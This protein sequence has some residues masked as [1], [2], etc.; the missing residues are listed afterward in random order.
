MATWLASDALD[1]HGALTVANGWLQLARR[2]LEPLATSPD[3]GWLAFHEGFVAR[4]HDDASH[5]LELARHAAEC[6]RRFGVVDL[7][8]L[9]LALEG[10]TL[11]DCGEVVEG[12][13]TLD[14]AAATALAGEADIP[15]SRAWTCC[16]LVTACA[17]VRDY[18]RAS[19]WCDRIAE[20]AERYGSRYMLAFCRAEYGAIDVW[21]GRWS[22][23]EELLSAAL[24]DFSS[25]RPGWAGPARIELA[26]LKRRQGRHEEAVALLERSDA[27]AALLVRA[28]LELDR[29]D[30][31]RAIDLLERALR[32]ADDAGPPQATI[33]EVL[34]HARVANGE[35]DRA[36]ESLASLR[37]IVARVD[38]P[39]LRAAADFAEGTLEA[40]RGNHSAARR[41]L[42]DAHDVFSALQ[43]PYEA[44]LARIELAAVRATMGEIE[45]AAAEARAA[46][47]CL[48]ALGA[49]R[50]TAP[51]LPA[52][53]VTRREQD[54][55]R[56][57]AEGLT[58]REIAERLAV[59]EHTV[60]RHITN[61]LRKLDLSSRT[62][63]AI[64]AVRSGLA[65]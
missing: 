20:F 60:H 14:E 49:A 61:I 47:D 46:H 40:A 22:S 23:A 19:Q 63:A 8:M 16:F 24:E 5:A 36:G 48:S 30:P 42:E 62:A 2:L 32:R 52:A 29:G 28:R 50:E 18:E 9:G 6:G 4:L 65:D 26:E 45:E 38:T 44:S 33:L 41:R 12:M 13:R 43:A 34:V 25:S 10:A 1:F 35:I 21:R 17:A 58:N 27:S 11:V 51:L 15:M 7:E 39:A 56:L 37:E 53:P 31:A 59:S 57:L 55:L 64:Y 54:V 3:H